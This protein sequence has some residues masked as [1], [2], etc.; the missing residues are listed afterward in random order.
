MP[1]F[2]VNESRIEACCPCANCRADAS[3][4]P[5]QELLDDDWLME[6]FVPRAHDNRPRG[7]DGTGVEGRM[8][9]EETPKVWRVRDFRAGHRA[10]HGA[11]RAGAEPIARRR[12]LA[13]A[14]CPFGRRVA[15]VG[16]TPRERRRIWTRCHRERPS[17]IG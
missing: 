9:P 15:I 10:R 3:D 14:A 5:E 1:D 2:E 11:R 8:L 17:A 7:G 12:W 4:L 6:L 13:R 16:G